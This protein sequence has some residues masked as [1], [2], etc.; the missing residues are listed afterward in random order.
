MTLAGPLPREAR[1]VEQRATE[2]GNGAL[3]L[4]AEANR[5]WWAGMSYTV[6]WMRYADQQLTNWITADAQTLPSSLPRAVAQ[7]GRS[8]TQPGQDG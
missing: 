5:R 4:G 3:A 8:T 7:M 6:A 1:A 2:A